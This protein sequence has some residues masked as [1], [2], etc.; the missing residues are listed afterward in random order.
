MKSR[1]HADWGG[2]AIEVR[3][4]SLDD[5]LRLRLLDHSDVLVR[6]PRHERRCDALGELR[7]SPPQLGRSARMCGSSILAVLIS[8]ARCI[9]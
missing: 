5:G 7:F 6:L 9:F 3:P 2:L 8:C 4:W 1:H